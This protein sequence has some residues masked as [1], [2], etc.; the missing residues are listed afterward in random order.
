MPSGINEEKFGG[1]I[2]I[3]ISKLNNL[4]QTDPNYLSFKTEMR[5]FNNKTKNSFLIFFILAFVVY[6]FANNFISRMA[7]L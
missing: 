5:K 6:L 4:A 2:W 7:K 1:H 3:K